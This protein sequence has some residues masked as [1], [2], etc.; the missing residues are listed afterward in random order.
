M[1]FPEGKFDYE[2]LTTLNVFES[3]HKLINVKTNLY[4]SHV[5]GRTYRYAHDL[6]NPSFLV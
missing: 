5:T 4:H 6:C 1:D 3:I 2:T